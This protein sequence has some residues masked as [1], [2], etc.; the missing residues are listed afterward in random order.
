MEWEEWDPE[1]VRDL[2][3]A[4]ISFLSCDWVVLLCP[5]V[6][7]HACCVCG[8]C[9]IVTKNAERFVPQSMSP[10]GQQLVMVMS[11]VLVGTSLASLEH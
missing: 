9:V 10:F 2:P 1:K 8:C 5:L 3:L 7:H 6:F 4:A 11:P